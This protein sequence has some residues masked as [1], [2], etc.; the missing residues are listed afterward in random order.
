[1][2]LIVINS[3]AESALTLLDTMLVL[4]SRDRMPLTIFPR[5][6]CIRIF[7]SPLSYSVHY[8]DAAYVH[9]RDNRLDD[10]SSNV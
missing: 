3:V 4:S 6:S 10:T 1:M 7:V 2:D 8:I 9:H 5:C